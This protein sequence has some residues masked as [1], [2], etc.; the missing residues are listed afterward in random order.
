MQKN[1]DFWFIWIRISGLKSLN[2]SPGCS[3][4]AEGIKFGSKMQL[5]K[6]ILK[7]ENTIVR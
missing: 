4:G 6:L 1:L 3:F 7:V 5:F 2:D